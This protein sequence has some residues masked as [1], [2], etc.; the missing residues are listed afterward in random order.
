MHTKSPG[1]QVHEIDWLTPRTR[2]I[3]SLAQQE[4]VQAGRPSI[5]P[6]HLLLGVLLQGESTAAT[7]LK[8][9]GLDVR[10]LRTHLQGADHLSSTEPH[11]PLSQAAEGCIERA[12]A[13]IAY[14]LTRNRPLAKVAP[15]HLVLSVISHPG[16]QKLLV[17]HPVQIV[18]LRQHLTEGMEPAFL[19]HIEALSLFPDRLGDTGHKAMNLLLRNKG[20]VRKMLSTAHLRCLSCQQ[21]IQP[22]WK[23]CTYCGKEVAKKCNTCGTPSPNVR[24]AKF[25]IECGSPI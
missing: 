11:P 20:H 15:E 18:A 3:L 22:Y 13:M 9:S 5:Q 7:L 24:G 12:I 6:E 10:T 2:E 16:A 4:A 25:C 1:P 14:Y 23:Y 19:A 21:Q 8:K 17:T